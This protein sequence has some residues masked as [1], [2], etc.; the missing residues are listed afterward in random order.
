MPDKPSPAQIAN[1]LTWQLKG[2]LK[3][4]EMAYVVVAVRLAKI[5]DEEHWKALAFPTIEAYAQKRLGL[6][7]TTLFHC[8]RVHDWLKRDHPAWLGRKPPGFIPSLSGASAH[9]ER[10][11]APRP[12]SFRGGAE[13]SRGDAHAGAPRHAHGRRVS[14]APR[15]RSQHGRS[16]SRDAR[17]TEAA[18]ARGG[19]RTALSRVG[20]REA[21]DDAIRAVEQTLGSARETAKLLAP[22]QIML[23]RRALERG[24]VIA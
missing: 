11:S 20:A 13:G 19:S 16:A 4:A 8:L 21:I 14:C 1:Q 15:A 3:R 2:F 10:G 6:G 9:V 5:R 24:P 23:A 17:A 12:P 7:H 18:P 22:R